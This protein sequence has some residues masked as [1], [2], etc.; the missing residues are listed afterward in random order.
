MKHIKFLLMLLAVSGLFAACKKSNTEPT[1]L[2]KLPPATQVGANTFGCLING[3]VY[4]PKG[5]DGRFVNSRIDIDPGFEDG[6]LTILVYKISNGIRED[7]TLASDSI[8][9]VG[10]Y[11]L[12]TRSKTYFILQKNKVDFT[13]K[14]CYVFSSYL[15]GNPNNIYGFLK[16]TRYDLLNRVFSGEFEISFNSPDCGYGDPVKITQGRFDYKL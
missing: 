16:I 12:K 14:Y 15:A 10:T 9:K 6:G 3:K 2:S 5:F 7:I 8:K 13:G 11:E 4:I 1:E